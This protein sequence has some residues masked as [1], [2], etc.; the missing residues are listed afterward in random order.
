MD[1]WSL[2]KPDLLLRRRLGCKQTGRCRYEQRF[3]IRS[4]TS[5]SPCVVVLEVTSR[6]DPPR[7][8]F[9]SPPNRQPYRI[10]PL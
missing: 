9:P 4:D 8:V 10:D 6:F 5:F 2:W 1:E 7:T 3:R